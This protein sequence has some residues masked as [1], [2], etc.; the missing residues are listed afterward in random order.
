MSLRYNPEQVRGVL[1]L[2]ESEKNY[3]LSRIF[4]SKDLAYY[5][6]QYWIVRWDLRN[7]EPHLQENIPHPCVHLVLENNN[8]RIVGVVTGKYSYY[9]VDKGKIFGFKFRPGGFYPFVQ[10]PVSVL[11]DRTVPVNEIFN[12]DYEEFKNNIL[13]CTEDAAMVDIAEDFLRSCLPSHKDKNIAKINNIIDAI[14]TDRGITQVEQL[15]SLFNIEKRKVQRL[16]NIYVGVSPKWVIK[17]YRLHE[18]LERL[19]EQGNIDWQQLITELGY[20]DQAHF[21]KDFKQFVGK[22]PTTYLKM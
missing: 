8:S 18:I 2:S 10:K 1:K 14:S 13:S 20:F 12:V 3:Q 15:A 9:L 4:P 7:K 21:I 6:E 19:E 5:I 16:F 11:T 22:S 17:K